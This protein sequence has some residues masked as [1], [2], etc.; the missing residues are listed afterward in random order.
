MAWSILP[1]PGT[2]YGPCEDSC[3]HTDCALTRKMAS[4]VCRICGRPIGYSAKFYEDPDDKD[5]LVHAVCLWGANTW[6]GLKDEN[7]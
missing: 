2:E 3:E 4:K 6:E 7:R 1:P 5:G